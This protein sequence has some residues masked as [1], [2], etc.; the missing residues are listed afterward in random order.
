MHPIKDKNGKPTG[1]E[2][3]VLPVFDLYSKDIG[4][5]NGDQRISA[6]AYEIRTSPDHAVTLKNVLY[7]I[8]MTDSNELT[9]IP[10]EMN[11]LGQEKRNITRSMIIKQNTFLM[12]VAVLSIFGVYKDEEETFYEIF[13]NALYFFWLRTNKENTRRRKVLIINNYSK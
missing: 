5:G 1:S 4:H 10:Y 9:L 11:S 2:R 8:S 12:E 3:I 7:K 6:F 13:S